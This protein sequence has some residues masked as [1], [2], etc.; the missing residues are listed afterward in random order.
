MNAEA[1][2]VWGRH[3]V[4]EALRAGRVES[5]LVARSVRNPALEELVALAHRQG[6]QVRDVPDVE[7]Q[8]MSPGSIMQGVAAYARLPLLADFE[9]LLQCVGSSS[10]APFILLL[11][12]IQDPHNFGALLR[13]SEAAGVQAVIVPDRRSAPLSGTVAKTSAGALSVLPILRV[14]NLVRTIDDLKKAGIWIAGLDASAHMSVYDADLTIPLALA[15]GSEGSG[16]R[17]LTSERCDLLLRLP[18]QGV[19]QSLNA[20]VAGSIALFERVRQRSRLSRP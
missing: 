1:I 9:D 5:L 6:L 13:S 14:T 11:D 4:L 16:L 10:E 18:M 15:I 17:R 2:W 8:A 20:S 7:L 19:I 3:P 12:Q